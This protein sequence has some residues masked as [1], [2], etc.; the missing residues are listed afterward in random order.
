[1]SAALR[2]QR[3]I[4]DSVCGYYVVVMSN[5]HCSDIVILRVGYHLA[6]VDCVHSISLYLAFRCPILLW[7]EGGVTF[8]VFPVCEGEVFEFLDPAT[9]TCLSKG[10]KAHFVGC[11][12]VLNM[13]FTGTTASAALPT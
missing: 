7:R 3:C 6:S 5:K 11:D 2:K 13:D 1:M 8:V 4:E 12:F 9:L 10:Y